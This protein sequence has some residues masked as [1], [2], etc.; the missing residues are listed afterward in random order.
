MMQEPNIPLNLETPWGGNR[1]TGLP[2]SFVYLKD[3]NN[4]M[5]SPHKVIITFIIYVLNISK[6]R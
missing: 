4:R 2:T 5:I 6:P 3:D 1:S